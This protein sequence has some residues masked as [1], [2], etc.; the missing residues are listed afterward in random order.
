MGSLTLPLSYSYT[1]S[2]GRLLEGPDVAEVGYRWGW[3]KKR[4]EKRVKVKNKANKEL[5]TAH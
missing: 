4:G 2:L 3:A 5:Q 1:Q